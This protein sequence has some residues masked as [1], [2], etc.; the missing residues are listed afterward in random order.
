MRKTN[1]PIQNRA[2]I[3]DE[4]AAPYGEAGGLCCLGSHNCA[5]EKDVSLRK[6]MKRCK[7]NSIGRL[8]MKLTAAQRK[9][10]DILILFGR[11]RRNILLYP[12]SSQ[13]NPSA[14]TRALPDAFRNTGSIRRRQRK[15]EAWSICT[16]VG[17][18]ATLLPTMSRLGSSLQLKQL[19]R[20]TP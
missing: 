12:Q 14:R 16:S 1:I 9:L 18:S 10:A 17:L 15:K 3:N 13:Y 19:S 7:V 8:Y 6:R 5:K 11:R 2:L 4:N 20:S